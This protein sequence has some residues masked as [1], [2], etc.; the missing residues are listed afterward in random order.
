[1]RTVGNHLS[2]HTPTVVTWGVGS[3]VLGVVW[4][5]FTLLR[6][7]GVVG[8]LADVIETPP[9]T[10]AGAGETV[11]MELQILGAEPARG[12]GRLAALAIAVVTIASVTFALQRLLLSGR[13]PADVPCR[14]NAPDAAPQNRRS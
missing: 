9:A 6:T 14:S 10:D 8:A 12:Y 4:K 13:L 3:V 2:P 11:G 5:A 7:V 1:V